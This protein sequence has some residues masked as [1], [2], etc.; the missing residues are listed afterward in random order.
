MIRQIVPLFFTMD[1]PGTLGYYKAK[2]CGS[3]EKALL[4]WRP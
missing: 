3:G 4:L 2:S 1:I